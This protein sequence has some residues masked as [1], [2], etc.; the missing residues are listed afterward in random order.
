MSFGNILGH[1][2]SGF[3][4]GMLTGGGFGYYGYYGYPSFGMSIYS[5]GY[6]GDMDFSPDTSYKYNL[7][8]L[9]NIQYGGFNSIYSEI[10]NPSSNYNVNFWKPF[11]STMDD[12]YA[13]LREGNSAGYNF[14]FN[15][16]PFSFTSPYTAP[17]I[18]TN[19][20]KGNAAEEPK[21]TD[22]E[23]KNA[24]QEPISYDA[25]KL[26]DKW[27]KKQPQLTDQ[28]YSRVVEI[29]KKI[30]CNPEHL[31]AIMNL[32]TRRTFSPSERNNKSSTKATGLIQFTIR[33]A[34]TLGTTIDELAK[35]SA[36]QQLDYVEKYMVTRK[37]SAGFKDDDV[38]SSGDLY[39]LI[40]QP[41]YAKQE[42]LAREGTKAYKENQIL[43]KNG[44][45]KITKSDLAQSLKSFM[46]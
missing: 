19:S 39:A 2:A 46:A 6:Y 14:N 9:N 3:A 45:K 10:N 26:K 34:P 35:M 18:T 21:D 44:D 4:F 30:K 24:K 13:K 38:L 31:M 7:D 36:V 8:A 17:A 16:K 40:F 28:F 22:T 43:D 32:E 12:Y 33:T 1:F 29:S 11:Q 15:F 27:S 41:A 25:K 37:K 5:G 42:V 20:E 23:R